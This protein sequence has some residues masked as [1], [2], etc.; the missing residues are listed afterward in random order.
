MAEVKWIKI[1]TDIFDD[2]K[3]LLIESMPEADSIIVIWFK[4]LVLAGKTN[5]KGVFLISDRIPYT[6]EMLA[7]IFRRKLNTIRLA[8]KTF[9]DFGMIEII[10]GVITIPNWGKHQ[11]LDMIDKRREYQ[12]E[13]MQKY[14]EKQKLIASKPNSKSNSKSNSKTN[15]NPLDIDIEE[16]IDKEE[17]KN[18]NNILSLSEC[19]SIVDYYNT[20]CVDLPK[21]AK[22]TE[23]RKKHI[24]ARLK[25]F[26][27]EDML[28]VFDKANESDFL[29]GRKTDWKANFD[30]LINASNF[31]KVLEGNYDNKVKRTSKTMKGNVKVESEPSWLKDHQEYAKK[32]TSNQNNEE[33]DEEEVKKLLQSFKEG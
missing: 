4:L 3:I 1:V 7:T 10:D 24:N 18:K 9:E 11:T 30:W 31:V 32:T 22:L 13:Y 16:D 5:N 26:T 21:V 6:E 12:R 20:V 23:T 15:V 29:S 19:Q 8:L 28:M 17:D 14:R 33:V 27:L 25:D 2:E